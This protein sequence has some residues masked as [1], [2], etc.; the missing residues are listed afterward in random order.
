MRRLCALL[1]LVL[2]FGCS[3]SD[4]TSA[5]T[6][7]APS[8]SEVQLAPHVDVGFGPVG[9]TAADDGSVWV[10]AARDETVSRI[11]AGTEAPDLTVDVPGVPLRATS[12]YDAIW[13]TSFDGKKLFRLDPATG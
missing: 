13:V 5:T 2:L 7:P 6:D 1:P 11:P 9:L 10:V 3:G 8:E 4:D 12:A